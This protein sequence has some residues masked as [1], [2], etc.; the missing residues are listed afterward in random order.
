MTPEAE[1]VG[2]GSARVSPKGTG[3]DAP[4]VQRGA[5]K[6]QEAGRSTEAF[7]RHEKHEK[8]WSMRSMRGRHASPRT[9]TPVTDDDEEKTQRRVWASARV[10]SGGS[11]MALDKAQH[12]QQGR[13]RERRPEAQRRANQREAGRGESR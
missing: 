2:R 7:G 9:T 6:A 11:S 8:H 12:V 4:R 5:S 10:G 1:G 3:N 13:A